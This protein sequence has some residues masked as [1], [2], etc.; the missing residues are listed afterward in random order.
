MVVILNLAPTSNIAIFTRMAQ[1]STLSKNHK[2]H[3]V[4]ALY[5]IKS[6][7]ILPLLQLKLIFI[8]KKMPHMK[9]LSDQVL[10]A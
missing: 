1:H 3:P 4:E 7:K 5:F 10:F 2:A 8:K 9:A 6:S